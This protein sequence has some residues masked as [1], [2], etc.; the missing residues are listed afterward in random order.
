MGNQQ[1]YIEEGGFEEYLYRT[2]EGFPKLTINGIKSNV[3]LLGSDPQG[4]HYSLPAYS[5]T[6]DMYFKVDKSGKVC[7]GRLYVDRKC[8]VDFDWSHDHINQDT[9]ERFSKGTVHVQVYGIDKNG[10]IE[11]YSAARRMSADEIIKYGP[12]IL[13]YNP[14]VKFR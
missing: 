3:L 11:R 13:A 1:Q 14:D 12:I 4:K 10:T 2:H 9:G 5:N 8:V 7:Q 6:S